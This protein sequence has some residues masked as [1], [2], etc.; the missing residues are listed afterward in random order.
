M[1][2]YNSEDIVKVSRVLKQ[3]HLDRTKSWVLFDGAY[4]NHDV[5][6]G[7]GL[8]HYLPNIHVFRFRENIG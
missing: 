3:V 6:V 5:V 7:L 4:R 1:C 8:M 2:F